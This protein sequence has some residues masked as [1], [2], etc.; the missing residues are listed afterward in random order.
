MLFAGQLI[1]PP[2]EQEL[3]SSLASHVDREKITTR[4]HHR[5]LMCEAAAAAVS[6]PQRRVW[7]SIFDQFRRVFRVD[8]SA[9][10]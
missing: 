10:I 6:V 7:S 4:S 8:H 2:H 1:C 5:V 3:L 9:V